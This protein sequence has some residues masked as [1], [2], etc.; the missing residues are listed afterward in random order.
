MSTKKYTLAEELISSI[1]HGIGALI[2]I[3]QLAIGVI[4]AVGKNDVWNIVSM[5]IYGTSLVVL[6]LMSTLYHALTHRGAKAVFRVLD[7][8][9][10][11]LLIAGTYTP[12]TLGVL[13]LT[14]P[15][16]A[17]VLFILIWGSAVVGIIFNSINVDK[18]W[19]VSLAG[20]LIMGWAAIFAIGPLISTMLPISTTLLFAGG[21]VYS[22][23]AII[24]VL[25]RKTKYFHSIWHFFV[26]GGS[27]LHYLSII[28]QISA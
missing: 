12:Y 19:K 16:L 2:G 11:F 23:G 4:V 25:G 17:W 9:S 10:I 13:R 28:L 8:N 7:H 3:I 14:S 18:Y 1:S 22:L 5:S 21:I 6:F 24:Y 20:Y 15:V 26:L 27:I